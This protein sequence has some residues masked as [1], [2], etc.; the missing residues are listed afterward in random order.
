[1]RP[2]M[3]PGLYEYTRLFI[4]TY[5]NRQN[6]LVRHVPPAELES[7]DALFVQTMIPLLEQ[8]AYHSPRIT[9]CARTDLA[10]VPSQPYTLALVAPEAHVADIQQILEQAG[11]QLR[12]A[13]TPQIGT[14]PGDAVRLYHPIRCPGII[15]APPAGEEAAWWQVVL[16][17]LDDKAGEPPRLLL[18]IIP[19]VEGG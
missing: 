1:M 17:G 9:H 2:D 3:S 7:L 18:N 12:I 15:L 5:R 6:A 11:W 4:H 10:K 14:E 19:A 13:G 16:T 8:L